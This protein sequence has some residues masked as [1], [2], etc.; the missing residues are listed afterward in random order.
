MDVNVIIGLFSVVIA[1]GSFVLLI[2][3]LV[4][5]LIVFHDGNQKN[6]RQ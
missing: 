6:N 1:F 4:V 3:D 2:I 5:T